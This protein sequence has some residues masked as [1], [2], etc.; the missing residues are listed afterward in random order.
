MGTEDHELLLQSLDRVMHGEVDLSTRLYERLFSRHPE[1]RELFGPNSI[2]VQEEMITETLISAVDDLE[3]LPWI[4]DNMQLLSQKHSD[5]DVTSEMYDWW[6]ECVIETLAELS[7]PD[8]NR[9][10]EE[11]W[12]K[13]IARLCELMRAETTTPCSKGG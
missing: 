13:Q 5:A 3:G 9:R 7:A 2:P 8:W 10:L 4:E 1:L 12:R 11:L 6:A